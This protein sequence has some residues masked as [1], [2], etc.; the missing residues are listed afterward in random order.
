MF[1]SRASYEFINIHQRTK[2]TKLKAAIEVQYE[3]INIHQRTKT[4]SINHSRPGFV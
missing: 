3:F 4:D 1:I 2:T